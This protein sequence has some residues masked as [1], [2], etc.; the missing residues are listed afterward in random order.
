MVYGLP[1]SFGTLKDSARMDSRCMLLRAVQM[2][3]DCLKDFYR[4]L[5]RCGLVVL[6]VNRVPV[7]VAVQYATMESGAVGVVTCV[8]ML[9]TGK[10]WPPRHIPV[11]HS[12]QIKSDSHC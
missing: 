10:Y 6:T 2:K 5:F 8:K 1:S 7:G 12:H 3:E 4:I 9:L 11:G